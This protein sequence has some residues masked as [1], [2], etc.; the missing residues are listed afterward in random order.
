MDISSY[1]WVFLIIA[2]AIGVTFLTPLSV[3]FGRIMF[4][5]LKGIMAIMAI[6]F[7]LVLILSGI[8]YI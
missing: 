1:W 3:V 4:F 7:I 8:L 2:I 5:G 6:I